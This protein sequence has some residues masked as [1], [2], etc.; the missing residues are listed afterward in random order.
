MWGTLV[1]ILDLYVGVS[2]FV[3]LIILTTIAGLFV[4]APIIYSIEVIISLVAIIVSNIIFKY[5]FFKDEYMV[6]NIVNLVIYAV[7]I[8]ATTIRHYRIT[9]KEYDAKQKLEELTYNEE[10]TGLLNE[11]SYINFTEEINENIKNND[12]TKFAVILMDVNNLKATND[13]YGHRYG[14]HLIVR[15]GH[16]LP[17]VFKS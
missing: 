8:I 2:P 5:E 16:T 14:C 15:C 12:D 4:I 1:C 10:L 13:A 17:N 7:V 6:E 3:Y 9:M 11:R